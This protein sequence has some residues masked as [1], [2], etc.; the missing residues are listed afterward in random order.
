MPQ[1]A[2]GVDAYAAGTTHRIATDA[3]EPDRGDCEQRQSPARRAEVHS[4]VTAKSNG[5]TTESRARRNHTR[6]I[7][8][9]KLWLAWRTPGSVRRPKNAQVGEPVISSRVAEGAC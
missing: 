8:N 5:E 4:A 3:Q 6:G 7:R 2:L 9:R 1:S